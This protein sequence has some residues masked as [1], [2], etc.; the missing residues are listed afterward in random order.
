MCIFFVSWFRS[1]SRWVRKPRYTCQGLDS[2]LHRHTAGPTAGRLSAITADLPCWRLLFQLLTGPSHLPCI[3]LGRQEGTT[4]DGRAMWSCC[5]H[6]LCQQPGTQPI[7]RPS[8]SLG[9]EIR[10]DKH[11]KST[12]YQSCEDFLF[13]TIILQFEIYLAL[14]AKKGRYYH[15]PFTTRTGVHSLI[16]TF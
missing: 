6:S 5:D 3:N 13:V 10:T 15:H 1:C 14:C 2:S 7:L 12:E 4:G 9:A 8:S 11:L 16:D